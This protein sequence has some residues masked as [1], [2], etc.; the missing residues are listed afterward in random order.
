MEL[1][2]DDQSFLSRCLII[3]PKSIVFEKWCLVFLIE[4]CVLG[5]QRF[6]GTEYSLQGDP[7]NQRVKYLDTPG[8]LV[9]V[10]R[11]RS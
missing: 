7:H 3:L 8:Q 9:I 11:K 4:V 6:T 2:P 10:G 1:P 5:W